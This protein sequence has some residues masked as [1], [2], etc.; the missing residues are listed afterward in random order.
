MSIY[1]YWTGVDI[2]EDRLATRLG[3][4]AGAGTSHQRIS[5][6]FKEENFTVHTHKHMTIA[7]LRGFVDRGRPVLVAL[8]AWTEAEL[9]PS[10]TFWENDWEDGH[11]SVVIGMDSDNVFLMDPSTL[12]FYTFIPVDEFSARWHDIAGPH[13][14]PDGE[15]CNQMGIVAHFDQP[16]AAPKP[17]TPARFQLRGLIRTT[18][19]GQHA[20][21]G[22]TCGKFEVE[23]RPAQLSFVLVDSCAADSDQQTTATQGNAQRHGGA[24]QT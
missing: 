4:S 5:R 17:Y 9:H 8:Q 1:N 23:T 6:F 15:I 11:Y 7:Q 13:S 10:R 20:G 21:N 18:S 2:R 16:D 19:T 14:Y 22:A 24:H 3:A 12:G